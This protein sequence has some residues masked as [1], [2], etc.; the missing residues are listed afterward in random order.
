MRHSKLVV[1]S[2]LMLAATGSPG[3]AES[4]GKVA[5]RNPVSE[6]GKQTWTP[7]NPDD[8]VEVE[9][10]LRTGATGQIFVDF[11]ERNS[12][13]LDH[14]AL[15]SVTT[16]DKAPNALKT[17]FTLQRGRVRVLVADTDKPVDCW[18]RTRNAAMHAVGTDFV[19]TYD[20]IANV[21]KVFGVSGVVSVQN[22]DGGPIRMIAAQET[23][24]V[25][26]TAAATVPARMDGA[27]FDVAV[28]GLD[29]IASGQPESRTVDHPALTGTVAVV[30]VTHAGPPPRP[31]I[32][33]GEGP[34]QGP[35][36]ELHQPVTGTIGNVGVRF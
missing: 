6:A 36:N 13:K 32:P 22:R 25:V 1:G 33:D 15:L 34:N 20:P 28:G 17:V 7:V 30:D 23:S 27:A 9:R 26:K 11:D 24:S 35:G 8:P 5:T 12:V 2:V 4:V 21:T 31:R 14:D 16:L 29:F 3:Y 19:V 18:V 10:S